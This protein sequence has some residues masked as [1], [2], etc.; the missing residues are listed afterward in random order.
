MADFYA[1]QRQKRADE[2]SAQRQ[3]AAMLANMPQGTGA[4]TD[5][6][7]GLREMLSGLIGEAL[8]KTGQ[9]G[10]S[11]YGLGGKITDV[12]DVATPFGVATAVEDMTRAQ[13]MGDLQAAAMGLLPGGKGVGKAAAKAAELAELSKATDALF[14]E[15]VTPNVP[16][17]DIPR[18]Q[19][20]RGVPQRVQDV[21]ADPQV[22]EGMLSAIERGKG[23]GGENWYNMEPLRQQFVDMFGEAEGTQRFNRYQDYVA[24][25]SPRS[26]PEENFRN[27]SFYYGLDATGQ[28]LPTPYVNP[29]G[30]TIKNPE[31]YGH[32]AQNLHRMNFEKIR[33]GQGLDLKRNPKPLGFS[34]D[35]KGNLTP[36][37]VDT[38]A[39][40]LPAMLSQDPRF[41]ETG[42]Q[43]KKG[44]PARNIRKEFERGDVTMEEALQ[45]P[46]YWA[47][48]PEEN[49]YLAMERFYQSLAPETGLDPGQV[50]AAAWVGGGPMTGLRADETLSAMDLFKKRVALTAQKLGQDPRDVL[51]K[52]MRGTG[53]LL[54]LGPVG[55]GAG[56]MLP[57]REERGDRS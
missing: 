17:H 56:A 54:S 33:S 55:L 22:R 42:L 23:M 50:Q 7:D 8:M 35:L 36:V 4:L 40:R 47:T 48:Q 19:P 20:P 32:L 11:A 15:G 5:A 53:P 14:R 41:L 52:M 18:Y 1:T 49:E 29:A 3:L 2:Q 27:A 12:A 37:A 51:A 28:P 38:H 46:A 45:R 6:P 43:V 44:E 31:P 16:Q 21:V 34:E 39:F 57:R 9:S 24:G 30:K 10:R 25:S 13:D 26:S